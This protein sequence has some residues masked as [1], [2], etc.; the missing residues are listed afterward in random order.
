MHSVP[1]ELVD[2]TE[3]EGRVIVWWPKRAGG[4]K[5]EGHLVDGEYLNMLYS[6]MYKEQ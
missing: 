1:F 5:L 2:Y 6:T 4:K 3:D